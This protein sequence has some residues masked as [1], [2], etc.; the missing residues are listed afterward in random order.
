MLTQ[1]LK[2]YSQ[3]RKCRNGTKSGIKSTGGLNLNE[4]KKRMKVLVGYD[5]SDYSKRA[6]DQAIVIT[7][8]LG[9]TITVLNVFD[10]INTEEKGAMMLGDIE[11]DKLKDA[12]VDYKLRM[13]G[14]DQIAYTLCKI[15]EDEGFDLI[16]IGRKGDGIVH[17][18]LYGSVADKVFSAAPCPVLIVP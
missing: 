2:K 8:A 5:G 18:W 11:K 17:T 14:S 1:N 16:A 10:L 4:M 7:K 12:V 15:A 13:E 6:L 3:N 9:G